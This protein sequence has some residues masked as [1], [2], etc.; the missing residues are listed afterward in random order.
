MLLYKKTGET[1]CTVTGVVFYPHLDFPSLT[2]GSSY[3]AILML[4]KNKEILEQ[5]NTLAMTNLSMDLTKITT[6]LEF[7][8]PEKQNFKTEGFDKKVK[9]MEDFMDPKV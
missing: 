8:V 7:S 5:L 4:Y 2:F 9:T 3:S 1:T 6:C